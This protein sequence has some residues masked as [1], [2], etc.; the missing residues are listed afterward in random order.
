MRACLRKQRPSPEQHLCAKQ[1][2]SHQATPG[3]GVARVPKARAVARSSTFRATQ[4][5]SDK[6][7]R[8]VR[9]SSS[10]KAT[11][12]R[13]S[14]CRATQRPARPVRVA[15]S[16]RHAKQHPT[17]GRARV[18][19]NGH[20]PKPHFSR[21]S[22][23]VTRSNTGARV[24]R[25]PKAVARSSACALRRNARYTKQR[26][27]RRVARRPKQT[28]PGAAPVPPTQRPSRN[29]PPRSNAS[30]PTQ[31]LSCEATPVTQSNTRRAGAARSPKATIAGNAH[32]P[33]QRPS[34]DTMPRP[35]TTAVAPSSACRATQRP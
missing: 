11:V 21:R 10:P 12:A 24:A 33:T 14:A 6:A 16:K 27:A 18:E 1:R 29:T 5:P 13:S 23:A 25:G 8:A 9:S 22:N 19:S 15:E 31:H 26:P 30:H 20:R 28:S 17:C 34:R 4:R 3:H 7:T 2:P 35:K 32:R